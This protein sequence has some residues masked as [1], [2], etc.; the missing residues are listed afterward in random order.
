MENV[1]PQGST[2]LVKLFDNPHQ[3]QDEIDHSQEWGVERNRAEVMA[4]GENV[5]YK[6]GDLLIVNPYALLD[7]SEAGEDIEEKFLIKEKDV[8]ATWQ[9]LK[10]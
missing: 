5:K 6:V 8:L 1:T 10:K 9:K 3:P 2:L 4:V 7:I